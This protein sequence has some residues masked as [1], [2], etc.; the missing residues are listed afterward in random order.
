MQKEQVS[1]TK[2]SRR[3]NN[4]Q[5]ANIGVPVVAVTELR[6]TIFFVLV[7]GD[8]ADTSRLPGLYLIPG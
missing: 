5:V 8:A 7:G 6:S 2:V 3:G 1:N 4:A